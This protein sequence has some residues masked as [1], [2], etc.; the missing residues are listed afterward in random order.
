MNYPDT[1][2]TYTDWSDVQQQT[3]AERCPVTGVPTALEY[4]PVE[5]S[6]VKLVGSDGERKELSN[7][8][9]QEIFNKFLYE[10]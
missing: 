8:K 2:T 5:L 4:G 1:D 9:L 7:A 6:G 3:K 10:K